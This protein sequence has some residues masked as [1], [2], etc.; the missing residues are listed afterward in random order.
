MKEPRAVPA[1]GRNN[2]RKSGVFD[3]PSTSIS[4]I[5]QSHNFRAGRCFRAL[6][7]LSPQFIRQ[8][9]A[10][11]PQR[12]QDLVKIT[13]KSVAER[14][15][16]P[17]LPAPGLALGTTSAQTHPR[18]QQ[19][20]SFLRAENWFSFLFTLIL[21]EQGSPHLGGVVWTTFL[22]TRKQSNA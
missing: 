11:G 20:G 10:A 16:N 5:T 3:G 4:A 18:K 22:R 14:G 7:N 13:S 9:N 2:P 15:Q 17:C 12:G 1:P 8:D 19:L 6:L 21:R